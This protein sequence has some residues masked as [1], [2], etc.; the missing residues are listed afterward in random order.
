MSAH[1]PVVTC[2]I[3]ILPK[4]SILS[5]ENTVAYALEPIG[6]RSVGV[7]CA[8]GKHNMSSEHREQGHG[9]G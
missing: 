4:R 3:N 8:F 5:V 6:A 7:I 9:A 1:P 2:P